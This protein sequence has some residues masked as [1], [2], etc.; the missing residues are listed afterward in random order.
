VKI[1][2]SSIAALCIFAGIGIAMREEGSEAT[3]F[4]LLAIFG[5]LAIHVIHQW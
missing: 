3:P 5:L 1:L 2:L 4:M